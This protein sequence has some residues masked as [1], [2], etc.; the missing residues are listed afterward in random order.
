MWRCWR[1]VGD[2]AGG[3][4]DGGFINGGRSRED[5]E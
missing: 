3:G 2:G 4:V 1:G 5:L